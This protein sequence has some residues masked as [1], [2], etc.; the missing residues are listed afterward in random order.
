MKNSILVFVTLFVLAIL[1][2]WSAHFWNFTLVGGVFLFA[3]A[4]FKDKKISFML[5]LA[6]MLVSDYIIGFHNQ[7]LSVYLSYAV[8]VAI[9]FFLQEKSSRLQILTF[10]FLG[11]FLFYILTNFAVWYQGQMYPMTLAGLI[12]CYI[13]G[14]P[15]YRNQLISDVLSSLALF[16]VAKVAHVWVTEKVKA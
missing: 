8:V 10:S 6:T 11:T 14:L 9:G 5:M 16:E 4:Y 12:D 3:G 1:S 7:M 15:F 2:R 13:M